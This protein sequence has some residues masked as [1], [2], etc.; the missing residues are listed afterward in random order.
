MLKAQTGATAA[1]YYRVAHKQELDLYLDNQMQT[2][3]CYANKQGLDSFTVYADNGQSGLTLDRPAFNALKADI[4]AGRIGKVIIRDFSRIA[5]DYMLAES[6]IEWAQKRD[7]EIISV[8][9]GVLTASPNGDAS[10][11]V[12]L[13]ALLRSFPKGGGRV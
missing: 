9:D 5:R 3:L 6:F 12:E 1:L 13:A 11:Y 10:P 4:E 7:V 2:L 8:Q